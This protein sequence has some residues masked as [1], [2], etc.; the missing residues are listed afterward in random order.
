MPSPRYCLALLLYDIT[1]VVKL[2]RI[3]FFLSISCDHMHAAQTMQGQVGFATEQKRM[4]EYFATY[5]IQ[6]LA[7]MH[8]LERRRFL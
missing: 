6:L 2:F 1:H 5:C 7:T 4:N 3:L 8:I